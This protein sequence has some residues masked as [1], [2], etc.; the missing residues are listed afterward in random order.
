MRYYLD[1][2][3]IEG[4]QP[5]KFF[6]YTYGK[7]K[8]TIDLISIGIV[9]E[10]APLFS[11]REGH[12]S[13]KY[14]SSREYYAVSKDFNLDHAWKNKWIRKNVL[15]PIFREF[16]AESIHDQNFVRR[17]FGTAGAGFTKY[18]LKLLINFYGKSNKKIA[19]EVLMF[20]NPPEEIKIPAEPE[21]WAYYADYDWVVFCQLFGTMMD[22]PKGFPMY[23]LDL[24]QLQDEITLQATMWHIEMPERARMHENGTFPISR[25]DHHKWVK[26]LPDYPQQ[27]DEHNALADARWNK[28][29]HKFLNKLQFS[30][31]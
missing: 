22:L 8:P 28:A 10:E 19:T 7:T 13:D 31:L 9:S 24:K 6:G 2:E 11:T 25:E 14:K 4:P 27:K 20:V 3:F 18:H 15:L 5:K 23:C 1:T 12:T 29:L 30:T 26:T 21:F 16:K 17:Y